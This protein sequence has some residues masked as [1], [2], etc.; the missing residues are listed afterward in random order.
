MMPAFFRKDAQPERQS[1]PRPG[2]DGAQSNAGQQPAIPC[3]ASAYSH[4]KFPVTWAFAFRTLTKN[5]AR[6]AVT[7]VGIALAAALLAAVLISAN[8]VAA[9]L[10]DEEEATQGAWHARVVTNDAANIE[11]A[12]TD[13]HISALSVITNVGFAAAQ[14]DDA[15]APTFGSYLFVQSIDG[16]FDTTCA[17]PLSSGRMP[18]NSHE[19]VLYSIYEN[20]TAFSSE[21]CELGSSIT[22][23]LGAVNAELVSTESASTEEADGLPTTGRL[24]YTFEPSGLSQTYTVVGFYQ[25]AN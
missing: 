7:I 20:S 14:E 1:A 8:S 17:L 22:V 24:T 5:R 19:I 6:T 4:I 25:T 12:R 15:Q 3:E 13:S 18:E 11:K 16:N 9:F 21:P 23:N 2:G 10:Y